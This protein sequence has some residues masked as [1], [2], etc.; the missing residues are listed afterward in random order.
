MERKLKVYIGN[1][2]SLE[3]VWGMKDAVWND[4]L[5]SGLSSY[6]EFIKKDLVTIKEKYNLTYLK[7]LE[8]DKIN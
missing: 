1:Y 2:K 7:N 3:E 8:K 5:K 6:A 4:F